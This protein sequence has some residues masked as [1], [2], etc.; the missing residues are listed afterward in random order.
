MMTKKTTLTLTLAL[1]VA[2]LSLG[3]VAFTYV[4]IA[5]AVLSERH[6]PP[7]QPG[8]PN[9]QQGAGSALTDGAPAANGAYGSFNG[10]NV[11]VGT[12]FAAELTPD[13]EAALIEAIEEEYGARSLYEGV[14]DQFANAAPFSMIARSEQQHAAALIR[15]A[16]KYG[17]E[18]PAYPGPAATTLTSLDAACQAGVAAEIAD[19]ALYDELLQVTDKSDLIRVFTRL[20]LASLQSHLTA[21]EACQ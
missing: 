20:Q 10:P 9:G 6:G 11:G 5:D 3:L 4:D 14:I 17:L 2:V 19:A 18:V 7:N 21:F 13:E 15:L 12:V 8:Q 16:D 1:F